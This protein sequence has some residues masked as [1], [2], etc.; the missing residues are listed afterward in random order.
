MMQRITGEMS[1]TMGIGTWHRST[2]NSCTALLV[3]R[4]QHLGVILLLCLPNLCHPQHTHTHLTPQ[5]SPLA[6]LPKP[7]RFWP[8]EQ[9]MIGFSNIR[10]IGHLCGSSFREGGGTALVPTRVGFISLGYAMVSHLPLLRETLTEIEHA[11]PK[12][13]A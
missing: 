10:V 4:R 8:P 2:T 9:W 3:T 1:L 12:Y 11:H 7:N 13:T 6:I 5:Q